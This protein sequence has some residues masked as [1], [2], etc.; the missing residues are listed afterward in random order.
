M[1][2]FKA[3]VTSTF[4]WEVFSTFFY[5]T[6]WNSNSSFSAKLLV[7]QV[8]V[9]PIH[10]ISVCADREKKK[11]NSDAPNGAVPLY[12]LGASA[13]PRPLACVRASGPH[14][15]L[16][17]KY[18]HLLQILLTAL[19]PP[20]GLCP[21]TPLGASATP[22]PLACVRASGPH[23]RLLSKYHRLL[24]IVLTALNSSCRENCKI[25]YP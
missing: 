20:A 1:G 4:T 10:N 2:I 7:N 21:C 15:R 23:S 12:L 11:H 17:S 22:R 13:A 5:H 9:L 8:S 24:Q 19:G 16:L 25:N 18:H 3:P 14:S 6:I